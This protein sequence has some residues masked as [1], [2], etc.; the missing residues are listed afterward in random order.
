MLPEKKNEGPILSQSLFNAVRAPSNSF[1]SHA[2]STVIH[3][4]LILALLLITIPAIRNEAKRHRVDEVTLIAPQL[5][6]YQPR[7][8][9]HPQPLEKSLAP[10]LIRAYVKPKTPVTKPVLD[11]PVPVKS[12]AIKPPVIT[13]APEIKE[14]APTPAPQVLAAKPSV[15]APKPE[16]HTGSFQNVDAALTPQKPKALKV[17]AF[18]D[19]TGALPS[20]HPRQSA[21]EVARLGAFD[22]P[23]GSGQ[24]GGG[25]KTLAGAVHQT[26]FGDGGESPASTHPAASKNLAS[27]HTGAFET[28]ASAPQIASATPPI[29]KPVVPAVTPV[30]IL[31][32][33]QPVYTSE[34]RNLKLEGEVSLEVVFQSNGSLRVIRVVDGLGHGLDEA[35]KHAALQVRFRPATR[36]GV[37]VDSNATIRITFQ[38]T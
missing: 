9:P 13:P 30:E 16:V 27:I 21:I 6:D 11:T 26:S 36:S 22:R 33:P 18:G 38:L 1:R 17:G 29:N 35:A 20:D 4:L 5:P 7:L 12:A 37:P 28:P 25:G 32:K 34:A 15:P 14:I 8:I 10:V 23:E 24:T 19:P 31:S 3:T 2:A